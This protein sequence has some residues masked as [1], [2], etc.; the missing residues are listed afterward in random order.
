MHGCAVTSTPSG[1][2]QGL[3][4]GG[5]LTLTLPLTLTLTL[6]LTLQVW[7]KDFKKADDLIAM[8]DV[9]LPQGLEGSMNLRVR[10]ADPD[11]N[12]NPNPGPTP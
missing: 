10:L 5:S 9:T 7:D 8:G 2:G 12:P 3:Q 1:V 6:T 4:E 11:P